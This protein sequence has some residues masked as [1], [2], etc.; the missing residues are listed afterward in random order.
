MNDFM[1]NIN[2]E[3]YCIECGSELHSIMLMPNGE[4]RV[5]AHMPNSIRCKEIQQGNEDIFEGLPY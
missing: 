2:Y 5:I 4:K 1:G 3:D